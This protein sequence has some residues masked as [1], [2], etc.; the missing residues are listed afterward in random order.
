MED[1]TNT[2]VEYPF[3]AVFTL[4]PLINYWK[5]IESGKGTIESDH[6]RR[7]NQE[8]EKAPE[9]F[10]PIEDYSILEKHRHLIDAMLSAVISPASRD[11]DYYAAID[12]LR[13]VSFYETPRFKDLGI[14]NDP[15][16]FYKLLI[17]TKTMHACTVVGSYV[18]ILNVF[19]GIQI[20]YEFPLVY[21]YKDKFGLERHVRVR[22]LSWFANVKKHGEIEPLTEEQKKFVFDNITNPAAL[23]KVIPSEKFSY[24]GFMLFHAVDITDQQLMGLIQNLLMEKDSI[25]PQSKHVQIEEKLRALLRKPELRMGILALPGGI[26]DLS[27]GQKFG[28]CFISNESDL[29]AYNNY[30]GSIYETVVKKRE[31][32]IIHD[33]TDLKKPTGVENSILEQGMRNLYVA[34]LIHNKELVGI[35]EL[36]SPNPGDL[37]KINTLK[38]ES[39][40]NL[41]AACLKSGMEDLNKSVQAVIKEK[42][43]AIHPSVEWRFRK[44]ALDYLNK[45]REDIYE[46]MEEI[47]FENVYPLYGVSD[48]RDSSRFRNASIQADLIDNLNAANRIIAAAGKYEKL[49]ILDELSSRISLQIREVERGLSSSDE[50]NILGFLDS[51]VE[52]LFAY[53]RKYGEDVADLIADYDRMIDSRHGFLYRK[54]K[55]FDECVEIINETIASE[56][57]NYEEIAQRMFPH[58]FEKYK[59]DGVE[60]TMYLGASLAENREF[61]LMYL[62]NLRLWQIMMMC[63]I[64]KKC[65]SL[66]E[67]LKIPLETTHLILV[68]NTPTTIRFHYD[69]KKFDVDGSYNVRYEILKKRIDKA[70]IKG[71]EERLTQ[72]GKIAVVY[73]HESEAAEYKLYIDYLRL[74]GYL[75]DEVEYLDLQDMQG[76]QGLKAIRVGVNLKSQHLDSG[77]VVLNEAKNLLKAT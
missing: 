39:V 3:R 38:L 16:S 50:A 71:S 32:S 18:A 65:K 31:V 28:N 77:S 8:L 51:E 48:I 56:L 12:P 4:L 44:A 6:A 27:Q 5:K 40:L 11:F 33:I 37:N 42:C 34:P 69:E 73:S 26:T 45:V 7:I 72:P 74:K 23:R 58:Y 35:L 52:P 60:H 19:Y 21:Q 25:M 41:L 66:K 9:L 64:T 43:T 46:E 1:K 54:R 22:M 30:H 14:F 63:G 68:Q 67:S 24:D 10:Q 75:L 47:V 55:D 2:G 76:V 70:E 49:P 62:K 57:D 13:M 15:A 61:N 17:D 36:G 29:P 59:T 20:N 53:L